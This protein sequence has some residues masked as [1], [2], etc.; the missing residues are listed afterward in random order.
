LGLEKG[1]DQAGRE[2]GKW[3]ARKW[4][5]GRQVGRKIL[6]RKIKKEEGSRKKDE[7]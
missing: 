4:K 1:C 2:A 5:A 6:G 3:R 7:G